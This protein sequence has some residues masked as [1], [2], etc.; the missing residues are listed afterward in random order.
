MD[1][2]MPGMDGLEATAA[3]RGMAGARFRVLPIIALTANA[4][5]G[6]KEMFLQNGFSD[7][8]SKPIEVS[9]LAKIMERWISADKRGPAPADGAA[10][11][12]APSAN[13]PDIEGLDAKAGL[14]QAGGDSGLYLNLLEM[15]CR[16]AR[17][18]LPLLTKMP[19]EREQKF[20]TQVHALKSALA[21]IGAAELAAA[22]A[23]LEEAGRAGAISAI[24]DEL[25]AFHHGLKGLLERTEAALTEARAQDE[26]DKDEKDGGKRQAEREAELWAQLKEALAREDLEAIDTAVEGL[27]ALPLAPETREALS[28]I[29]QCILSADFKKAEESIRAFQF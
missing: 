8:L 3:I 18:R 19:R 22:A 17:A 23:R 28:G 1:H 20:T 7:F 21:A 12:A 15:F 29:A 6:M 14:A 25:N 2:M 27:K 5:T 16:D 26:E 4:V 10:D 13:L 9:K 24:H 11:A